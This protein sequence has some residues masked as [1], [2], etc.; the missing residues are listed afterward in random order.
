MRYDALFCSE[1][2]H[3]A[4]LSVFAED[5]A[6]VSAVSVPSLSRPAS[7]TGP[8]PI[9]PAYACASPT[10]RGNAGDGRSVVLGDLLAILLRPDVDVR[11]VMLSQFSTDRVVNL[12][13]YVDTAH[14]G[15]P[16]RR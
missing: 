4:A 1:E 7:T 13:S 5:T 11:S 16:C 15:A 9:P 6:K 2:N 8:S 10:A 12:V 14:A 3:F